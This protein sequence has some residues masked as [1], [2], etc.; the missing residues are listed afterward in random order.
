MAAAQGNPTPLA[1]WPVLV[2]PD[3]RV[4][5]TP[6]QGWQELNALH[7]L[8]RSPASSFL[9]LGIGPQE[10]WGVAIRNP[11]GPRLQPASKLLGGGAHPVP[12]S[13]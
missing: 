7:C 8:H 9:Q 4:Y 11:A 10:A 12:T 2:L 1:H 6:N 13:A 5:P 3:H